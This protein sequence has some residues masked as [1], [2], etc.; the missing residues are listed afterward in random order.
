MRHKSNHLRLGALEGG[1]YVDLVQVEEAAPGQLLVHDLYVDIVVPPRGRR[2]EVLDLD[3]L[4]DALRDGS[5]DALT[6]AGVLRNTQRFIDKHLRDLDRE[7]PGSWPDF[8]PAAIRD[9]VELPPF[10]VG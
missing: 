2:Y 9:L 10:G 3:E 8:P 5:I 1:W 6:A 4:A 7:A